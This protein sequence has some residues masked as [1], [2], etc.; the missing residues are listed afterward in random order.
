MGRQKKSNT[1]SKLA[2]DLPISIC[3][4]AP[5]LNGEDKAAYDMLL[6]QVSRTVK[7]KD[8]IEGIWLRDIVNLTRETFRYRGVKTRL[9]KQ[10]VPQVLEEVLEP[11]VK[12]DAMA[13]G[14]DLAIRVA[15]RRTPT[16]AQEIIAGCGSRANP[17]RWKSSNRIWSGRA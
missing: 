3:A 15:T 1:A 2:S 16:P 8:A 12:A 7:P 17:R 11:K 4:L 14:S 13:S 6:A 9:I 5:I 10:A